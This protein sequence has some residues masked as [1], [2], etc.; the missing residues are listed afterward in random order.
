MPLLQVKRHFQITLP[1]KLRRVLDLKE[2]DLMEAELVDDQAIILK[3]K[4]VVDKGRN[5]SDQQIADW[6]KEDKLDK[7]T[8]AKAKKRISAKK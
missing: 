6:I 5:F 4:V 2:G 7:T 8:L 3:P 1:S